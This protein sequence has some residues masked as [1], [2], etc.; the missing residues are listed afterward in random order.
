MILLSVLLECAGFV[1]A[2]CLAIAVGKRL[3]ELASPW[4]GVGYAVFLPVIIG[5]VIVRRLPTVEFH[6]LMFWLMKGRLDF[7]VFAVGVSVMLCAVIPRL[8]RGRQR[9]MVHLLM[10][11]AILYN[12]LPFAL[13]VLAMPHQMSLTNRLSHDGICL[14]SNG[15]NC[16]PA[17]AVTALR[18]VGIE[19]REGQL[20]IESRTAPVMGTDIVCLTEVL[21]ER[22]QGKPISLNLGAYSSI[23][24]IRGVD[25]FLTIV[26]RTTFAAHFVTVL[27]VTDED[28]I[29][30]DPASGILEM[31]HEQFESVWRHVGVTMKEGNADV[32]LTGLE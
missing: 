18:A 4:W 23:D 16:G 30:A 2:V 29:I 21:K 5:V 32:W 10:A 14:Q 17:A 1:L 12:F 8:K 31:T 15:F 20:A 3:S 6:P 11:T 19:A 7:V 25:A 9:G 27:A 28:V 24:E 22:C 13:P 26:D